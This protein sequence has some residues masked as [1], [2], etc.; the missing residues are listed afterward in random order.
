MK[1]RLHDHVANDDAADVVGVNGAE[2]LPVAF[3]PLREF[4]VVVPPLLNSRTDPGVDEHD[5]IG[6]GFPTEVKFLRGSQWS[7]VRCIADEEIRKNT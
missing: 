2:T 3:H 1:D 6:D 4:R 7:R 5:R